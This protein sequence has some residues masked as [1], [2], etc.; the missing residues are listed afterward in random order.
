MAK[1]M[2]DTRET[3]DVD[4]ELSKIEQETKS[5]SKKKVEKAKP[6]KKDDKKKKNSK[7]KKKQKKQSGIIKFFKEVKNEVSKVKWPSKK[8]MIKYSI[9]TIVFIVFFALF[10]CLIDLLIALL[11]E[12]I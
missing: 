3:I 4:L 10:F 9:A 1:V 12:V 11:K 6:S 5:S 8:D 2:K 7:K